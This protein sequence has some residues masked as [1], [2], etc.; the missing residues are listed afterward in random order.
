MSSL[1][2]IDAFSSFPGFGDASNT[3][4]KDEESDHS[5][6]R[7]KERGEGKKKRRKSR[8]KSPKSKHSKRRR[9]VEDSKA[10]VKRAEP[11]NDHE[12]P[13]FGI[14]TRPD[15]EMKLVEAPHSHQVPKYHTRKRAYPSE[16]TRGTSWKDWEHD[17]PPAR[18]DL[19]L[20]APEVDSIAGNEDFV[21]IKPTAVEADDDET[22]ASVVAENSSFFAKQQQLNRAVA[23]EPGNLG[24]WMELLDFQEEYFRVIFKSQK[25]RRRDL[26]ERKLSICERALQHHPQNAELITLILSIN[27][28]LLDSSQML[29]KWEEVLKQHPRHLILHLGYLA[30]HQC[31]SSLFSYFECRDLHEHTMKTSLSG[32]PPGARMTVASRVT[33]LDYASGYR[34]RAL[35]IL[36]A[37]LESLNYPLL[38]DPVLEILEQRWDG[39]QPFIGDS[40]SY[41]QPSLTQSG[42]TWIHR[43]LELAEHAYPVRSISAEEDTDPESVVLFEDIHPFITRPSNVYDVCV[44]LQNLLGMFGIYAPL[45]TS[46]VS[47]RVDPLICSTTAEEHFRFYPLI[48]EMMFYSCEPVKIDQHAHVVISQTFQSLLDT[49]KDDTILTLYAYFEY[50]VSPIKAKAMLKTRLQQFPNQLYLWVLYACIERA[51]GNGNEMIRVCDQILVSKFALPIGEMQWLTV[52]CRLSAEVLLQLGDLQGV[53]ELIE[54]LFCGVN[55]TRLDDEA[56]LAVHSSWHVQILTSI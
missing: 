7:R 3:L 50:R 2:K 55:E 52:L 46:T 14:D 21:D 9:D 47:S 22:E 32:L 23:D 43:E 1:R 12:P 13:S 5:N 19:L 42:T 10:S 31:T 36:F 25:R 49:F 27:K 39:G 41:I 33:W 34:E 44:L 30:Y 16:L 6:R 29:K 8:S 53:R 28:E 56:L 24:G 18:A 11:E 38:D 4:T 17:E 45:P 37:S 51:Q 15:M 35:S 20:K 26:E 48:F 54:R 40:G